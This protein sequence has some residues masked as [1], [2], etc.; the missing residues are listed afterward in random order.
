[1]KNVGQPTASASPWSERNVSVMRSWAAA[2]TA[3]SSADIVPSS[4]AAVVADALEARL[5]LGGGRRVREFLHH[6]GKRGASRTSVLQLGLAEADLQ[7]R[8]RRLAVAGIVLQQSLEG[9]ER[10]RIVAPYVVGL[11][12]PIR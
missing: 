8:V 7:E 4:A 9:R 2:G 1:M 6:P 3:D 5:G 11:A 10:R 12:E